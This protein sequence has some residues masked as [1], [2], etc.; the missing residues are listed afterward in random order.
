[1]ADL[2]DPESKSEA[3]VESTAVLSENNKEN[4]EEMKEI[5]EQGM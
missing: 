5:V 2:P 3:E 4:S 1:M